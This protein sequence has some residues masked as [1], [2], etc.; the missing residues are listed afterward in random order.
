MAKKEECMKA[1]VRG[2]IGSRLMS[3]QISSNK[4]HTVVFTGHCG[5]GG[6]GVGCN[7]RGTGGWR[8]GWGSLGI[9]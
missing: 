8:I 1:T 5:R 7:N 9:S 6:G 2:T 4:V 3:K